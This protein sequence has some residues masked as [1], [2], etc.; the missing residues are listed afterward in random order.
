[1]MEKGYLL[2][3]PEVCVSQYAKHCVKRMQKSIP[4]TNSLRINLESVQQARSKIFKPSM[5]GTS[6]E[7]LMEMQSTRFPDLKIPWIQRTLIKLIYEKNGHKTEGIFRIAA[8]PE[9]LNA[10]N[11]YRFFSIL[12]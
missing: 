8:D 1:M 2:D 5:F 7:E 10:G 12:I 4:V 11:C 6:L 9:Q 3:M